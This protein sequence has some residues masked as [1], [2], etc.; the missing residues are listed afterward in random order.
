MIV[1]SPLFPVFG[2]IS[3]KIHRRRVLIVAGCG[4]WALALFGLLSSAWVLI[5]SIVVLGV[6]L[7][8][9]LPTLFSL[10]S[11]ILGPEEAGIGLSVLYACLNLGA[12]ISPVVVGYAMDLTNQMLPPLAIMVA[13]SLMAGVLAILLRTK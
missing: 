4:L 9:A 10:P 6:G 3:D 2:W 1:A 7:A 5:A 13:F 12:A 11:E 8:L